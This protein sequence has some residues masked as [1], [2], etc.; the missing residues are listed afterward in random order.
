M[1][2]GEKRAQPLHWFSGI[3]EPTVD[4]YELLNKQAEKTLEGMKA[5]SD[6]L[7]E[8]NPDER[9][10]TVRDLEREADEMKMNVERQLVSSFVTPFDR[11]DIYELSASLDEV[12]NTAKAVVREMDAFNVSASGT[13]LAEMADIL[14]EG[15][16]CLRDGIFALRKNLREASNQA[17]QA[18]KID[19]RSAKVY[20]QAVRDLLQLDDFKTIMRQKEVYKVLLTGAERIDKVGENLLHAIVKMS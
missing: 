20:R 2:A 3:F 11:E 14:V 10:Q 15:A 5:L 12:I 4:F 19:T 7:K 9:C 16:T 17:L 1:T 6:W 8:E 13:K 18:R